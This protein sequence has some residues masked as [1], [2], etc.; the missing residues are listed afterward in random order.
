MYKDASKYGWLGAYNKNPY[1]SVREDCVAYRIACRNPLVYQVL[2]PDCDDDSACLFFEISRD[3]FL[4]DI[5]AQSDLAKFLRQENLDYIEF[6]QLDPAD[7]IYNLANYYN[8]EDLFGLEDVLSISTNDIDLDSRLGVFSD[9][10]DNDGDYSPDGRELLATD[11]GNFYTYKVRSE[12]KI[13]RAYA[14]SGKTNL[15]SVVIPEGVT[16]IE[17]FAFNNCVSLEEIIIPSSVT[18]IGKNPFV[19][20]ACKIIS[21]SNTFLVKDNILYDGKK[22]ALISSCSLSSSISLD[23]GVVSILHSAFRSNSVIESIALPDSLTTISEFAFCECDNLKSVRQNTGLYAIGSSAFMD[24]TSLKSF[25]FPPT[26]KVLGDWP[27]LGSECKIINRSK[28]FVIEDDILYDREK[29]NLIHSFSNRKEIHLKKG[30]QAIKSSAF[31]GN[32]YI[33]RIFIPTGVLKIEDSSFFEC[34]SLES[35]SLPD[36]LKEIGHG[37]FSCCHALSTINLPNSLECIGSCAFSDCS[38]LRLIQLPESI[39]QIKSSTFENCTALQNISLPNSINEIGS[40]A[41]EGCTALKGVSFS[42][43]LITIGNN[44]FY[45]CTVLQSVFLPDSLEEIGIFAFYDC[46]SLKMIF[47]PE[48]I[49]NIDYI[50]GNLPSES[51]MFMPLSI[52]KYMDMSYFHLCKIFFY[53]DSGLD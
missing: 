53:F 21:R 18:T 17:D 19:G 2:A 26:L 6:K 43:S 11:E 35:V 10:D 24:C 51:K 12:T 4:E 28:D 49:N 20:C 41:F 1:D 25:T 29:R 3:I 16:T 8:I 5:F 36:S 13:I 22:K 27:F 46:I 33:K 50:F 23:S 7:M 47:I 14:F 52:K 9:L 15:V 45:G 32:S 42:E 34:I 48:S 39:S 30:L 38:S 31:Y 40:S 44:A 37:A